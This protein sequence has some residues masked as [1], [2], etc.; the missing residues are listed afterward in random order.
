MATPQE[1]WRNFIA[2]LAPV[3]EDGQPRFRPAG[4]GAT[5]EELDRLELAIGL[6][7]PADLRGLLAEMNGIYDEPAYLYLV[8][9]V[10]E[11]IQQNDRAWKKEYAAQASRQSW[12]KE[13]HAARDAVA[14][15]FDQLFIFAARGNGDLFGFPIENGSVRDDRVYDWDH[16]MQE[17]TP[18]AKSL[19]D[20]LL[21]WATMT[22]SW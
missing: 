18:F 10:N 16:E 1:G 5:A 8:M 20:F 2:G 14:I 6:A 11:I 21:Q 15:P 22:A 19:S 12:G 3:R 4:A 9:S 7:L 13:E 17:V